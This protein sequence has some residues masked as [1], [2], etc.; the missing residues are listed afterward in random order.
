MRGEFTSFAGL[1]VHGFAPR[2]EYT[3]TRAYETQDC[4]VR[5]GSEMAPVEINVD[6]YSVLEISKTA[7]LEAV[8]RSYRRLAK[9]HHPDKD[10]NGD[11]T[12]VFQLASPSPCQINCFE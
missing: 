4:G 9:V 1:K 12:A 7:T 2:L 3:S 10:L 11:S 6:Y 8:T 5:Y